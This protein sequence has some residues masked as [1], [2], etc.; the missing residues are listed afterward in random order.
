MLRQYESQKLFYNKYPYKLVWNSPIS[1]WFRGGDLKTIRTTL[2]HLQRQYKER[3]RIH[4]IIWSREVDVSIQELHQAQKVFKALSQQTDY[5]IRV[6]SRF[7]G[8]YS[9]HKDWL[10]ELSKEIKSG[11]T[12][13]WEPS[14][15]LQPN[16]MIAGPGLKG[17]EYKITLG[18]KVP[19]TFNQWAGN[20][21]D[22]LRIGPVL[23]KAILENRSYLMGYYFYVKNEKMLNLV[24]LVL[25]PGISRIDKIIIEDNNA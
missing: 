7:V 8:I 20:N 14:K 10:W 3:K 21:L 1:N 23:K 12:E 9:A 24:T 18:A 4:L 2:D 11:V 13:W 22:K 5:R 16:I 6:E 17:W 19:K 15:L 25:G